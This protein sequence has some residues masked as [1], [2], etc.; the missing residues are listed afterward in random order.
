LGI[1]STAKEAT[2]FNLNDGEAYSSLP[3]GIFEKSMNC[4]INRAST[5][6]G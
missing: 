3:S 2:K 4:M 6:E 1:I 5:S